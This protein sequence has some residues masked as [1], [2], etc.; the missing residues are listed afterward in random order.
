MLDDLS[1]ARPRASIDSEKGHGSTKHALPIATR[2]IFKPIIFFIY[3][4]CI[5]LNCNRLFRLF[6]LPTRVAF[7]TRWSV[8]RT[9]KY[10]YTNFFL[11]RS[12]VYRL[13][14]RRFAKG[15]PLKSGTGVCVWKPYTV[16]FWQRID[17]FLSLE[18]IPVVWPSLCKRKAV[19]FGTY[20]CVWKPYTFCFLTN[21]C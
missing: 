15:K 3:K 2:P 9:H 18:C 1:S 10:I 11:W 14:G 17:F 13:F 7:G 4:S 6:T 12:N 21:T 5:Q 19:E 20:V 16:V 8:N